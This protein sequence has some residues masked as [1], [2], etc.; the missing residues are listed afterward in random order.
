MFNTGR[1]DSV[2]LG[3]FGRGC[4]PQ[5]RQAKER[6]DRREDLVAALAAEIGGMQAR[7]LVTSDQRAQARPRGLHRLVDLSRWARPCIQFAPMLFWRQMKAL[8]RVLSLLLF[9]AI[10]G[11]ATVGVTPIPGPIQPPAPGAAQII[12]YRE[13]GYYEP[14]DVLR[15]A[16]NQQPVGV[17]PRGDVLYRDG[18]PVSYTITFSPT[19]PDPYQFKTV[20]LGPGQVVF[21]KLAALP[22]RP[23]NRFGPGF[24]DC[25]INGYTA[26]I[27]DPAVAEQEMQGLTLIAG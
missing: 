3:R 17:L 26:M 18:A 20:T 10:A 9:V 11:C 4:E 13:I 8:R 16:L 5:E 12:L 25:D 19:R 2:C 24:G 1:V 22:V 23:C 15:V 14:S 6:T 21:V 7:A 27:V